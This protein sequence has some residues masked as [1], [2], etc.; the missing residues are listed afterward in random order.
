[1]PV[2]PLIFLTPAHDPRL[3]I[4]NNRQ[5]HK[6]PITRLTDKAHIFLTWF[7]FRTRKGSVGNPLEGALGDQKT[8]LGFRWNDFN[9]RQHR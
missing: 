4:H 1:M 7:V 8:K 9:D 5:N 6:T 2:P 3:P